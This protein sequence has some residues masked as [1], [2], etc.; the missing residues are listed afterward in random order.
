M[1]SKDP[2]VADPRHTHMLAAA[3]CITAVCCS[4]PLM[5]AWQIPAVVKPSSQTIASS[6]SECAAADRLLAQISH[7]AQPTAPLPLRSPHAAAKKM[8]PRLEAPEARI[9]PKPMSN[10]DAEATE[11]QASEEEQVPKQ[12]PP[13]RMVSLHG[14]SLG[15]HAASHPSRHHHIVCLHVLCC[16]GSL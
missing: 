16:T 1:L 14:A 9:S 3:A 5:L 13:R 11:A 15:H 7:A 6:C 8:Q 2:A 12:R 4:R 10:W